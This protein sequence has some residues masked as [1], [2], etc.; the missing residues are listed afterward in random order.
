M[1]MVKFEI[2]SEKEYEYHQLFCN[3]LGFE[4]MSIFSFTPIKNKSRITKKIA[5]FWD[6]D[7]KELIKKIE[8]EWK[9][10]EKDYFKLFEKITGTPW[11]YKTYHAYFLAFSSMIGFSN[12][13]N[14]RSQEIAL[15]T[16]AII[17]PKFLV[18]HELFHSHYYYVVDK[19]KMTARLNKTIFTEGVAAL[20]LFKTK[21]KSLFPGTDT[22][23][24]VNSYPEVRAKWPILLDYWQKRL[25]F[26]DFLIKIAQDSRF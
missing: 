12:P 10:I 22:E 26:E 9:L 16:G 5:G 4:G 1:P 3:T 19:M 7:D 21:A 15:T 13:F 14:L 18:G 17:N 25:S 6:D 24:S 11:L 8:S 2:N 23:S 20:A